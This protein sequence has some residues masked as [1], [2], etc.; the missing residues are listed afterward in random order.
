MN[1][2]AFAHTITKHI[3][4][5]RLSRQQPRRQCVCVSLSLCMAC[6]LCGR[7][8]RRGSI[9]IQKYV[10]RCGWEG[11]QWRGGN[12]RGVRNVCVWTLLV[13]QCLSLAMTC[14]RMAKIALSTIYT[15]TL[16]PNMYCCYT[17]ASFLYIVF[18]LSLFSV[19]NE[20]SACEY[21]GVAGDW[22]M[23]HSDTVLI[24]RIQQSTQTRIN[25][26]RQ[27]DGKDDGGRGSRRL[28]LITIIIAII[29]T[30]YGYDGCFIF[31]S[32]SDGLWI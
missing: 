19:W 32:R 5:S 20:I 24:V 3:Q 23:K 13:G 1:E 12:A 26:H 7:T 9:R 31:G 21:L 11:E 18:F 17:S 10:C 30:Q 25:T 6:R 2:R 16:Y 4:P 28:A 27:G 15:H 14:R 22:D 29:I 8:D